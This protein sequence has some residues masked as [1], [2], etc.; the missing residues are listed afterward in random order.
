[1]TSRM[2]SFMN[3]P[4]L[5]RIIFKRTALSPAKDQKVEAARESN[6]NNEDYLTAIFAKHKIFCPVQNRFCQV[7]KFV[8]FN[9]KFDWISS[10]KISSL[11]KF[12]FALLQFK[13]FIKSDVKMKLLCVAILIALSATVLGQD[14]E[15]F[16]TPRKKPFLMKFKTKSLKVLLKKL[17]AF[18]QFILKVQSSSAWLSC[19]CI[20]TIR[21]RISA[22]CLFMADVVELKI[23]SLTWKIAWKLA[24]PKTLSSRQVIRFLKCRTF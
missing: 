9:L 3:R 11:F 19:Q 4:H 24:A 6:V 5:N 21:T 16:V 7:Q 14:D 23:G 1:M 18:C 20:A 10:L 2:T 13:T 22:S 8:A 17:F 15:E 12:K